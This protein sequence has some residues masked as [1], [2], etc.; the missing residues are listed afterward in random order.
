MAEMTTRQVELLS[1]EEIAA[2]CERA[3]L[4]QR[5]HKAI[6]WEH[7]TDLVNIVA[8]HGD[9]LAAALRAAALEGDG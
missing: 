6:T 4:Y 5:E 9:T 8:I 3:A 7:G 1:N 2:R